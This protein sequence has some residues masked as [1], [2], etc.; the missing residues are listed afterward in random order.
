MYID[1]CGLTARATHDARGFRVGVYMAGK[2]NGQMKVSEGTLTL[3][4]EPERI[5]YEATR[6]FGVSGPR[7]PVVSATGLAGDP[8]APRSLD[9]ETR[10]GPKET[11]RSQDPEILKILR[12]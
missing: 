10:Q 1:C 8:R 2:A 3:D 6:H 7:F 12:P 4:V 9:P 5:L 11:P